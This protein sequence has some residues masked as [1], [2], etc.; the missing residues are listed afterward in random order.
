IVLVRGNRF[1]ADVPDVAR[2]GYVL[3]AVLGV[4]GEAVSHRPNFQ[5]QS[6][7]LGVLL[8]Q[9]RELLLPGFPFAFDVLNHEDFEAVSQCAKYQ[10]EGGG[11][12]SLSV[13]CHDHDQTAPSFVHESLLREE[14]FSRDAQRSAPLR[15]A[16]NPIPPR[17]GARAMADRELP[18]AECRASP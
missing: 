10:T 13:T 17:A 18:P 8:E 5:L 7:M 6:Q 4:P 2:G 11:G 16:A 15:V 14:L 1:F 9:V 3:F 12:L